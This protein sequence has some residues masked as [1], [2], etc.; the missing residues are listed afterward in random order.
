MA[1]S[2]ATDTGLSARRSSWRHTLIVNA[3]APSLE[4]Q[5]RWRTNYR[6]T[7]WKSGPFRLTNSHAE[8]YVQIQFYMYMNG[9]FLATD[10]SPA[11]DMSDDHHFANVPMTGGKATVRSKVTTAQGI[12]G[13]IRNEHAAWAVGDGKLRFC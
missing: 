5:F 12:V 9:L 10:G 1:F 11:S 8:R 2:E 7:L 3:T 6:Q 4:D 13:Q